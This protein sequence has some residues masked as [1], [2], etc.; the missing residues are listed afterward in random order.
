MFRRV[1]ISQP[2]QAIYWQHMQQCIEWLCHHDKVT[3]LIAPNWAF[4][5]CCGSAA[6][7]LNPTAISNTIYYSLLEYIERR[8]GKSI[9]DNFRYQMIISEFSF[10][11]RHIQFQI[12]KEQQ[13]E[14]N[15]S[16]ILK[17]IMS[18]WKQQVEFNPLKPAQFQR[19][20]LPLCL[21][22]LQITWI[23]RD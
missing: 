13:A 9:S 16:S 19:G 17:L 1:T 7:V 20:R 10:F 15:A 8:R 3:K 6:P 11:P 4:M 5:W 18:G 21:L 22:I 23:W 14:A 12:P 2:L